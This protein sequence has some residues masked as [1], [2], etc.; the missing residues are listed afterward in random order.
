MNLEETRSLNVKNG[1][2]E[3]SYE[4]TSS[5]PSIIDIDKLT[6][7][8]TA[9]ATGTTT[10]NVLDIIS[11]G[12]DSVDVNVYRSNLSIERF[13][14]NYTERCYLSMV[15]NEY[16]KWRIKVDNNG[17]TFADNDKS[18]VWSN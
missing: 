15:G 13:Y 6:G 4:W 18:D 17:V 8:A 14:G 1:L 9:K 3:A 12:M 10:L 16:F 2:M 11:G 7:E 5:D